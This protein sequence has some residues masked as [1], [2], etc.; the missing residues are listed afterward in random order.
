MKTIGWIGTGVM[1]NA[2]VQHIIAAGYT[3][4]VWN[5]TRSKTENLEKLGATIAKNIEEVVVNSDIIFTIIGN[6][7]NV[8]DTYF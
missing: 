2:M 7:Q 8:R 4:T 1:G 5:R 3:V 6:P